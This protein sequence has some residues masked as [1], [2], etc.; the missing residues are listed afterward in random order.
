M[1]RTIAAA[2]A[3]ILAL[4]AWGD[5]PAAQTPAHEITFV[6]AGRLLADPA[7]GE[8]LGEKTSW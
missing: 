6:Q 1:K 8:V 3:A 2:V 5:R 4:A 7:T